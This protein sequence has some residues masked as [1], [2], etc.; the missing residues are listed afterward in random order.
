[1]ESLRPFSD[2][3]NQNHH[4]DFLIGQVYMHLLDFMTFKSHWRMDTTKIFLD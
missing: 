2:Y 1:M 3:K 4:P